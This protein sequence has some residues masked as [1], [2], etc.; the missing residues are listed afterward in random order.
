MYRH[1]SVRSSSTPGFGLELGIE[2][3]DFGALNCELT[4]CEF[5]DGHFEQ[6]N[7]QLEGAKS[8]VATVK[9]QTDVNLT[10]EFELGGTKSQPK[11]K[12]QITTSTSN[13]EVNLE[14]SN[15]DFST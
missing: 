1:L 15:Y 9:R 14:K 2:F 13:F 6:Q 3:E 10:S 5:G 12:N 4:N 11:I 7:H 8:E